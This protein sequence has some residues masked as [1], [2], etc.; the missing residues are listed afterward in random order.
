[1]FR[2]WHGIGYNYYRERFLQVS[3]QSVYGGCVLK[4]GWWGALVV[5]LLTGYYQVYKKRMQG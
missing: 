2:A 4:V 1:M 5:G 3:F